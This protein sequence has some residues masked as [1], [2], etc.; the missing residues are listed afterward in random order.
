MIDVHITLEPFLNVVQ[1]KKRTESAHFEKYNPVA[2]THEYYQYFDRGQAPS[3]LLHKPLKVERH[4]QKVNAKISQEQELD[5]ATSKHNPSENPHELER[6]FR[7]IRKYCLVVKDVNI[8]VQAQDQLHDEVNCN[9][10]LP[11]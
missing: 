2:Q 5:H 6:K 4:V 1:H 7:P 8:V 10:N 11:E 3:L 9:R